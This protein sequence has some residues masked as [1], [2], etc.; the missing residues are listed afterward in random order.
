MSSNNEQYASN[1]KVLALNLK[2]LLDYA[3]KGI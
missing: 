2:V 3:L 1:L